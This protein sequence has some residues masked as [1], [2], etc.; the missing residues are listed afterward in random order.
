MDSLLQ[1]E[2]SATEKSCLP[3]RDGVPRLV[4]TAWGRPDLESTR[5]GVPRRL[6]TALSAYL[7]VVAHF[8]LRRI[9]LTDMRPGFLNIRR[10]LAARSLRRNALWRYWPETIER[11]TKRYQKCRHCLPDHDV[12]LQYGVA[13]VLSKPMVGYVEMSILQ[14]VASPVYARTYGY[15]GFSDAWLERAVEGERI[16]L[17]HCALVW[18]NS[19]W[20]ADGLVAQGVPNSRIRVYPPACGMRDPGPI[21]RDWSRRRILF[22]GK[23]WKGKGGPLLLKAFRRV[24]DRFPDARLT[25]IGCSPRI[26]EEGVQVLGLL[27]KGNPQQAEMIKRAY[28]EACVYCMPT[29]FDTTGIVFF[30]AAIYGLASVMLCGQGR[31]EIFPPDTAVHLPEASSDL[32][33]DQLIQLLNDPQRLAD[34]GNRARARVLRYHTWEV[35][36]REVY[37]YIREAIG[38]SP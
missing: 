34:M 1:E 6:S 38:N 27:N 31:E 22:V 29:L 15:E 4:L 26:R 11:L 5:H 16:F 32:L 17:Q 13:G 18:T 25:I 30:E 24:R 35:T 37:G 28:T 21:A 14:A 9:R 12:V 33:A 8:D 19:K 36:A 2:L 23:D 20:T 3:P 7:Q 10:S